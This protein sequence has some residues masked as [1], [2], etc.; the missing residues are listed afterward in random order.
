MPDRRRHRG[1]HPQDARLFGAGMQRTLRRAVTELCYLLTRGYPPK[2]AL[3]LVGD[4]HRLKERQRVAV[5]RCACSA[6][7]RRSRRRRCVAPPRCA[8]RVLRI[9]AYNLLITL[10]VA[11]SGGVVL[12]GRDGALRDLA[13][14]HGTYRRVEE[15][16]RALEC[17]GRAAA[18]LRA[19]RC[20]F[21]IDAPVSN[22]GRLR[23]AIV[24][25]GEARAWPWDAELAADPDRL[26]KSTADIV[27]SSDSAI[28]DACPAWT[29]LA[30]HILRSAAPGAFV[31]EL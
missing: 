2:A 1:L 31:V 25:L 19:A 13:G 18:A 15:T 16:P 12:R 28:L 30:E 17:I 24:Q 10:E 7:R 23:R 26:L 14:L 5:E 20:H 8:G 21:Y 27:V 29:N 4:R 3:K 22:S 11:L 9:D 6:G